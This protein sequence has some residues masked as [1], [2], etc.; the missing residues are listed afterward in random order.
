MSRL[1]KSFLRTVALVLCMLMLMPCLWACQPSSQNEESDTSDV[2]IPVSVKVTINDVVFDVQ[3]RDCV[4]PEGANVVYTRDYKIG[5][6]PSLKLGSDQAGRTAIS[7]CIES[8][9]GQDKF[10]VQSV[11]ENN[12]KD[13]VIPYNG[14]VLTV[15]SSSLTDTGIR[16]GREVT[17]SE[18]S[19]IG[20]LERMDKGYFYPDLEDKHSLQKRIMLRDPL[21]GVTSDGVYFLS[22]EYTSDNITL[23]SECVVVTLRAVTGVSYRVVEVLHTSVAAANSDQL[24]FVGTYN[25]AYADT[26]LVPELKISFRDLDLVSSISECEALIMGETIYRFSSDAYNCDHISKSGVYLFDDKYSSVVTAKSDVD[27]VDVVIINDIVVYIGEKN[28]RNMLPLSGGIVVT[29]AGDSIADTEKLKV[30]DPVDPLMLDT[31][32]LPQNH[33]KINGTAYVYDKMNTVRAPEGVTALYTPGFG[34]TT[35]T[36]QYG[37]EI[38]IENGR[39]VAIEKGIGDIEIPQNGFVLSL[40]K[41]SAFYQSAITDIKVGDSAKLATGNR[42]YTAVELTVTG[43]N[44]T[45]VQD[46]LI[47]YRNVSTTATNAYGYEIMVDENGMMIGDGYSGNAMVPKGGFVLSGHGVNK[48]ALSAVYRYGG[49][50]YFNDETMKVVL[51]T[52]PDTL[53]IDAS[54][55]LDNTKSAVEDAKDKLLYLNYTELDATVA[56]LEKD[57]A[58]AKNAFADG[59]FE[60]ALDMIDSL[61]SSWDELQYAVLEAHPVENRAMWYRSSEKSDDEVRAVVEKMKSLNINAVYLETWYNGRF[62]GYSDNELIA[63]SVPNGNYDALDG[64]VR[65]CHEY[66]IEVHAWVENF[67]IGTVEAQEQANMALASHFE[68]RW[69]KDRKGKNTFFYTASNTNFI[70]MNPFEEEVRTLLVDFY[71]EIITK[72]DIDGLHLDY[73]RFP[74]LNY[75]SDDFGYNENIVSAWQA[76]NNTTVDPATLNGG[77]LH[78][79]WIKFRQEIINNFVGE[80]YQMICDTDPDIWLSAAVYPGIPEIKNDI[81]QDC[82]NWV[83]NGYVDELFSMSYGEDNSYVSSNASKFVALAGD[84]CFYSTGISAFGETTE[85]NFAKQMIEVRNAGSDGVAIFSLANINVSNYQSPIQKGSF[86]LPSVSVNKLN[87]TV[88]EQLKY[89]IDKAKNVY[90]PYAGLSESDYDLLCGQ[91]DAIIKSA[92]AF[93]AEQATYEEMV[94]YCQTVK[95]ELAAVIESLDGYISDKNK[96]KLVAEDFED[97]ISWMNK[98]ENRMQARIK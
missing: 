61:E 76:E 97:L 88:E 30:G 98:S 51:I 55:R 47:V 9:D 31:T 82:A 43:I 58:D 45:R 41:D 66:G 69:L 3:Y 93:D 80:V 84:K 71:R 4:P 36:N 40:H 11:I 1:L 59:E 20:E 49:K 70:F 10:M 7:V 90:V 91:L 68:G 54:I 15:P 25:C 56:Q 14:F 52:T 57:Y 48:D 79:S 50:V 77:S 37:I 33:I 87:T 6:V 92:Q 2:T 85:S 96:R 23:P 8:V 17:V 19:F 63:H 28:H 73:I 72:Y 83:Q 60:T 95:N 26:F 38:A 24:V 81:F 16:P 74:E 27:R 18:E 42:N 75:G 29:F 44:Q 86:R 67:F 89:I 46:A 78:Q 65:I 32:L 22:A 5:D 39:V 64:F 53:L 12:I 13:V 35:Q 62:I 21:D 34:A 94:Q